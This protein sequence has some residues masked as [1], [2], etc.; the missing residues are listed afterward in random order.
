[1]SPFLGFTV[2]FQ[3]VQMKS[4]ICNLKCITKGNAVY[5]KFG[6][7]KSLHLLLLFIQSYS[8]M[9]QDL[10]VLNSARFTEC[11]APAL[12]PPAPNIEDLRN[13]RILMHLMCY[14]ETHDED[15][16][17]FEIECKVVFG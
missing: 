2:G 9:N 7:H 10:G 15:A 6:Y 11:Q 4:E 3:K 16:F 5:Q 13:K 14:D 12:Q 8:S 17:G 1:L